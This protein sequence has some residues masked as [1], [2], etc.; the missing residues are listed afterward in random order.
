MLV[1]V[2][3]APKSLYPNQELGQSWLVKV[4][5]SS[6]RPSLSEAMGVETDTPADSPTIQWLQQFPHVGVSIGSPWPDPES[7]GKM[8]EEWRWLNYWEWEE[9]FVPVDGIMEENSNFQPQHSQFL[10]SQLSRAIPSNT[11]QTHRFAE[12]IKKTQTKTK[13]TTKS[14]QKHVF[15]LGLITVSFWAQSIYNN[16]CA[17]SLLEMLAEI[18]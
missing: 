11:L 17:V 1:S 10:C 4:A 16:Q 8:W 6:T 18:I 14:K 15:S 3:P 9:S 12:S 5:H 13:A 2:L 7:C